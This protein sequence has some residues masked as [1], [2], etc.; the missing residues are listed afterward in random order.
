MLRTAEVKGHGIFRK[1]AF[2]SREIRVFSIRTHN[3]PKC[4]SNWSRGTTHLKNVA[5]MLSSAQIRGKMVWCIRRKL[6][7]QAKQNSGFAERSTNWG[8]LWKK[9]PEFAQP[10]TNL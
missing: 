1:S 2:D 3:F 5:L 10:K 6:K 7:I 8:P 4:I 9:S